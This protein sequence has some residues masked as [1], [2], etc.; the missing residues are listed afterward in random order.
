M[1]DVFCTISKRRRLGSVYAYL[2]LTVAGIGSFQM[3]ALCLYTASV[4]Q[5]FPRTKFRNVS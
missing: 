3:L 4:F 2:S 5:R 1:K